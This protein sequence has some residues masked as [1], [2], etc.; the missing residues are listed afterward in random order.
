[1]SFSD[2]SV[3]G[4]VILNPSAGG[5]RRYVLL[6]GTETIAS[7]STT[8]VVAAAGGLV[9]TNDVVL[10]QILTGSSADIA[11]GCIGVIANSP[12]TLTL[13]TSANASSNMT[14]YYQ[15]LRQV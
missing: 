9:N 11:K 15:V 12:S 6:A 2:S 7:A 8:K 3:N 5:Q 13:T 10:C 4:S 14:I 1:M